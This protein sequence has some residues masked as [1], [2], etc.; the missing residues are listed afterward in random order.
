MTLRGTL[1]EMMVLSAPEIYRDYMTLENGKKILY[2][3]LKKA[4]Y[5]LLKSAL[6][7]YRKLWRDLARRGFEVNPC[8]PCVANKVIDDHQMTIY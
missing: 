4:L 3:R 7:F 5:G 1:A 6:L 2:V 8:D